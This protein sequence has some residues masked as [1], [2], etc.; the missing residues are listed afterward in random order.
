MSR[1]TPAEIAHHQLEPGSGLVDTITNHRTLADGTMEFEVKWFAT[2]LIS[3]LSGADLKSVIKAIDYCKERGL[4]ASRTWQR[5]TDPPSGIA[6]GR[7]ARALTPRTRRM[8][9]HPSRHL[10]E[11]E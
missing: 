11:R 4:R 10:G 6:A 9:A 2:D 1:A 8:T 7:D 5:Q 3:W